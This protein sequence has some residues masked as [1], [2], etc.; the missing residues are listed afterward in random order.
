V[1]HLLVVGHGALF[2]RVLCELLGLD[3]TSFQVTLSIRK[4][5]R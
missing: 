4:F 3:C 5:M 1:R 2:D